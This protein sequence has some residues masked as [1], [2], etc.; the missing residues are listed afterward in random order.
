MRIAAPLPADFAQ[1]QAHLRGGRPTP[2]RTS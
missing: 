2:T 1:A